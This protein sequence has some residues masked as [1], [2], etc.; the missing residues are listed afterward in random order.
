[1]FVTMDNFWLQEINV[2]LMK[3]ILDTRNRFLRQEMDSCHR[4]RIC[5][6]KKIMLQ[7]IDSYRKK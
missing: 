6:T 4:K 7:E 2:C 3:L 5:V 1:M